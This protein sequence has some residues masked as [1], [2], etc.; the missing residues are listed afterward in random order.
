MFC[1]QKRG[2]IGKKG[3]WIS[4]CKSSS[5]CKEVWEIGKE[6]Y[7]GNPGLDVELDK[8]GKTVVRAETYGGAITYS[9]KEKC[10]R[11]KE[12]MLAVG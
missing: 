11:G 10:E 7:S 4:Q 12:Q 5:V 1:N 8:W 6:W 3:G 2:R 9:R